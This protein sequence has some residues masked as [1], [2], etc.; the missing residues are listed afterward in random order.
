MK[1]VKKMAVQKRRQKRAALCRSQS[2]PKKKKGKKGREKGGGGKDAP[3]SK[4]AGQFDYHPFSKS[5]K[6][7]KWLLAD[8]N[9]TPLE[10]LSIKHHLEVEERV[11]FMRA[12]N[13]RSAQVQ[14]YPFWV[15]LRGYSKKT[16]QH[17]KAR[18]VI[19][20]AGECSLCSPCKL[21][22]RCSFP[23]LHIFPSDDRLIT[24]L[25]ECLRYS[26]I[27]LR[28]YCNVFHIQRKP[29]CEEGYAMF[30]RHARLDRRLYDGLIKAMAHCRYQI[31]TKENQDNLAYPYETVTTLMQTQLDCTDYKVTPQAI[32]RMNHHLETRFIRTFA[33]AI[34]FNTLSMPSRMQGSRF[35]RLEGSWHGNTWSEGYRSCFY[36]LAKSLFQRNMHCTF[37]ALKKYGLIIHENQVNGPMSTAWNM[38][39]EL[40][41]YVKKGIFVDFPT[42]LAHNRDDEGKQE[43]SFLSSVKRNFIIR[44]I[45]TVIR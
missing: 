19:H 36:N 28:L 8:P 29:I 13:D 40:M 45:S 43:F 33:L 42:M 17:K 38:T 30:G 26:E 10:D 44:H 16:P 31:C 34:T 39:Y 24:E 6:I 35:R 4:F 23:I 11:N 2:P 1:L 7:K 32:G 15:L 14:H 3:K 25:P 5:P 9:T 41:R 37:L 12:T 21:V 27:G 22:H 20:D 18:D